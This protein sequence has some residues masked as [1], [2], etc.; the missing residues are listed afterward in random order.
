MNLQPTLET[1]PLLQ[2]IKKQLDSHSL[3]V[4]RLRIS[5]ADEAIWEPSDDGSVLVR[6]M[7]W[8]IEDGDQ[9]VVEPEFEVL[10][11]KITHERLARELPS[12]FPGIEVVVDN[13]IEVPGS[14]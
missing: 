5:V 6:W 2:R 3:E 9:E 4:G 13:D 10:S 14:D 7:C 8:S 11:D 12:F 1:S